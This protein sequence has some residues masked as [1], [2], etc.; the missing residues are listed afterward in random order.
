MTSG[1]HLVALA[2]ADAEAVDAMAAALRNDG[3]V[4]TAYG[5]AALLESLDDEVDVVLVDRDLGDEPIDAV[6]EAVR[7]RSA[8]SQVALVERDSDRARRPFAD[9]HVDA[10]VPWDE[11]A[12]REAV[13]RLAARAQYRRR[14]DEY[15]ALAEARTSVVDEDDEPSHL[16]GEGGTPDH[17]RL[18]RRMERL[19]RELADGFRRIDDASAFD[20]ALSADERDLSDGGRDRSAGTTDDEHDRPDGVADGLSEET[21]TS[22]DDGS[23]GRRTDACDE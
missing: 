10:V 18:E 16:D 21:A 13:S 20:A 9:E 7:D 11:D 22:D 14:L 3:A 23:D 19:R 5:P 2:G 12:V 1:R 6:L 15:Y 4:R 17:D 8:A